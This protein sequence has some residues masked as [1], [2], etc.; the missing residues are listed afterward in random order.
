MQAPLSSPF[1]LRERLK[2]PDARISSAALIS[3]LLVAIFLSVLTSKYIFAPGLTVNLEHENVP[4][5]TGNVP[6]NAQNIALPVFSGTLAGVETAAVLT[7]KSDSMFILDGHIYD[8][9][10]TAFAKQ[11]NAKER[12]ILLIKINKTTSIQALFDI[13]KLAREAGFSA[14]QIAGETAP[15]AQNG[16]F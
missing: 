12:G 6:A 2:K 7:M 11:K 15:P 10:E 3:V 4:A 14:I 9:L 13:A 1:S 5:N 16:A 8:K